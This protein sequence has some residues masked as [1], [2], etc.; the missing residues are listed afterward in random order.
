MRLIYR[1]LVAEKPVKVSLS[2][3]ITFSCLIVEKR[4][5]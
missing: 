2:E 5:L 4:V 1:D 3:G